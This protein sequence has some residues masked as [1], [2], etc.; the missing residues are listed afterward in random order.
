MSDTQGDE[1]K[2]AFLRFLSVIYQVICDKVIERKFGFRQCVTLKNWLVFYLMV[3]G[4]TWA[5]ISMDNSTVP[6]ITVAD[7]TTDLL[8]VNRR[9]GIWDLGPI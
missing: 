6:D 2:A 4:I 9:K 7:A 3:L 5:E 8:M 1:E